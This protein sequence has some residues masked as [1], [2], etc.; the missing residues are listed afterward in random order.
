M[1]R[2]RLDDVLRRNQS[3]PIRDLALPAATVFSFA[4]AAFV[5]VTQLQV[6]FAS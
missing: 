6:V 2:N 1:K 3:Q 5:I 4:L